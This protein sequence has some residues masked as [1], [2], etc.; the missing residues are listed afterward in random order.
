MKLSIEYRL[1]NRNSLGE[2][3]SG[4]LSDESVTI[5]VYD[6]DSQIALAHESFQRSERRRCF[7]RAFNAGFS[8]WPWSLIGRF[9]T[10]CPA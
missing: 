10:G 7:C 8:L 3:Q 4:Y 9:A 6:E 1:Q 5:L 2:V